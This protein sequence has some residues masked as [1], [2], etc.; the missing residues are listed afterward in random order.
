MPAPVTASISGTNATEIETASNVSFERENEEHLRSQF[1]FATPIKKLLT[2][3]YD[4]LPSHGI[5][6][7]EHDP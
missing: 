2:S 1:V 7:S 4:P 5:S 3:G 6:V